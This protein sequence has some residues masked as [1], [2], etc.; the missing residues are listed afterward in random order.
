V[1]N[2]PGSPKDWLALY[3]KGTANQAYLDWYFLNGTKSTPS[4]GLT[5]A[6][7]PFTL[8]STPGAYEVRF[9]ANN[10]FQLVGTSPTVAVA[11]N[12]TPPAASMTAPA[13]GS[14]VAG[15]V[16]ISASATDNVGVAGVQFKLDGTNLG[17]EVTAAPYAVSWS[18]TTVSN[19]AHTLSAV[20]RNVAGNTATSSAVSVTVN[21]S[22]PDTNV[23]TITGFTPTSGS[24]GTSVT[25]SGTG[26]TGATAVSFNG[27][28][29]S[30]TVTSPTA[31]QTTVPTGATTGPLSV[32]TPGGTVTSF[33]LF[34]PLFV[35]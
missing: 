15:T 32:T 22:V 27:V 14:A 13:A 16:T 6:S 25:I 23:L 12:T 34:T 30:F 1:Q 31:I 24:G 21:N 19:G 18:T 33:N 35:F 11:N 17:A 8:P 9:F 5:A 7:V 28:S 2:G 3:A 26:F 20:A 10:T 4:A 29:A